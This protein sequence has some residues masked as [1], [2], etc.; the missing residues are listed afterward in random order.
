MDGGGG[1][2]E[3]VGCR[4][5][6]ASPPGGVG[7]QFTALNLF[8]LAGHGGPVGRQPG[9]PRLAVCTLW[10]APAGRHSPRSG[11][12]SLGKGYPTTPA[13]RTATR[14]C[15]TRP[16]GAGA[17]GRR[18]VAGVERSVN[19]DSNSDGIGCRAAGALRRGVT[20]FPRQPAHHQ[21]NPDQGTAPKTRD[22]WAPQIT[23]G[24][25][26]GRDRAIPPEVAP[27][28]ESAGKPDISAKVAPC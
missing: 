8:D 6:P 28:T 17:G 23:K 3:T 18:R 2:A 7:G 19:S 22:T 20:A 24:P 25:A 1:P 16:A 4:D 14:S 13:M 12:P 5:R 11:G 10:R 9:D 26:D 27:P 15:Q 21:S